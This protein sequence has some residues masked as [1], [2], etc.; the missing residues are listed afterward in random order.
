MNFLQRRRLA[1]EKQ[2]KR[3]SEGKNDGSQILSTTIEKISTSTDEKPTK[4]FASKS[5]NIHKTS[6]EVKEDKKEDNISSQKISIFKSSKNYEKIEESSGGEKNSS[7]SKIFL[8]SRFQNSKQIENS[9]KLRNKFVEEEFGKFEKKRVLDKNKSVSNLEKYKSES[10]NSGKG[11]FSGY[12]KMKSKSKKDIRKQSSDS[13]KSVR[14]SEISD[15]LKACQIL[16][17][18]TWRTTHIDVLDCFKKKI[19]SE[20]ISVHLIKIIK[21]K[22]KIVQYILKCFLER[23]KNNTFKKKSND[24][25]SRMF[26]K[27][28]KIILENH[29]KKLLSKKLY[30]WMKITQILS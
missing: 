15:S 6:N 23:W 11:N 3:E 14:L 8:S 29:Q 4:L 7:N 25:I 27:I 5:F 20:I 22:E 18:Y 2:K 9:P 28:I 1:Y 17:K 30:Q 21:T 12:Y 13:F 10:S 19:N 24:L 16:E 26:L